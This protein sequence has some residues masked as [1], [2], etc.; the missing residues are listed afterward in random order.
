MMSDAEVTNLAIN[1]AKKIKKRL[2]KFLVD[3]NAQ[4][5]NPVSVFMAGSPGAGKTE[6]ARIMIKHFS[7]KYDVPPYILK[8]MS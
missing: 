4:E 7:S 2:A 6:M 1:E 3:G 8:M 5:D